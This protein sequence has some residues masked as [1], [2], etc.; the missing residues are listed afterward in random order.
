MH[1]KIKQKNGIC[2][3]YI[4]SYAV[5]NKTIRNPTLLGGVL[6]LLRVMVTQAVG[7]KDH[8]IYT[9]NNAYD[10]PVLL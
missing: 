3:A 4:L 2:I 6:H 5:P 10:T 8:L 1:I 7:K 9:R